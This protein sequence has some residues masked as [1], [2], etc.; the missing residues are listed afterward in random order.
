MAEVYVLITKFLTKQKRRLREELHQAE[1]RRFPSAVFADQE[2]DVRYWYEGVL[3]S[4]KVV[5]EQK[6]HLRRGPAGFMFSP[7]RQGRVCID[8]SLKQ[9]FLQFFARHS[10][11][12]RHNDHETLKI[13]GFIQGS[14]LPFLRGHW[15]MVLSLLVGSNHVK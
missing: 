8:R 4:S 9:N 7:E 6:L 15:L 2:I 5:D 11:R 12:A 10:V 14:F 13:V 1:D 3:K